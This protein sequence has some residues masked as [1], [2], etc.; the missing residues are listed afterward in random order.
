VYDIVFTH[1]H[2]LKLA[3]IVGCAAELDL[4]AEAFLRDL[5]TEDTAPGV[6]ADEASGAR[7]TPT[8]LIGNGR[9][10]GLHATQTL[11]LTQTLAAFRNRLGVT[12][13]R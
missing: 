8:I 10:T 13:G 6:R 12:D 11:T 3:E 2:L 5:D 1:Q 4:D 9:H 7:S